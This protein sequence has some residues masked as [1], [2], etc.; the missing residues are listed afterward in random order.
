MSNLFW[1]TDAQIARLLL[2]FPKEKPLKR[3]LT[4][5]PDAKPSPPLCTDCTAESAGLSR[6]EAAGYIGVSPPTFD[7]M[8][9]AGAMPGQKRIGLNSPMFR[10]RLLC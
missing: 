5:K 3:K 7:K 1:L 8:V 9:L 6:G 4:G 10:G 2:F